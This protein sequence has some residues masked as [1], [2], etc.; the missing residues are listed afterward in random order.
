[1]RPACAE[2]RAKGRVVDQCADRV[3][4]RKGLARRNEEPGFPVDH[5]LCQPSDAG[6][7]DG[8]TGGHGLEG[9]GPLAVEPVEVPDLVDG[10]VLVGEPVDAEQVDPTLVVEAPQDL[11]PAAHGVGQ[12]RAHLL[13][14][15]R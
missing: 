9:L 2:S 14:V 7:D 1:M 11:A 8:K 5:E 13:L 12:P 15:L 6:P 10:L 3:R 4:E